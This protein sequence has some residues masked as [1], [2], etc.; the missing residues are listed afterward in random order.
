MTPYKKLE[1]AERKRLRAYL[2]AQFRK[3][4]YVFG[5]RTDGAWVAL[6]VGEDETTL[7]FKDIFE[8]EK[9]IEDN[10]VSLKYN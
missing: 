8:A 7:V 4:G 3:M 9:F 5:V 1:K 6:S 10:Y 2:E